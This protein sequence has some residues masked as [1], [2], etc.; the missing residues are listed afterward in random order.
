VSTL[1]RVCLSACMRLFET[2]PIVC[3]AVVAGAS[4]IFAI[5][6][7]SPFFALVV[8]GLP[9]LQP[10]IWTQPAGHPI[11]WGTFLSVL[12]WNTSGYDSVGALAAEV[13]RPGQEFPRAMV[14]TIF[15]VTLV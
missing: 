10:R 9:E 13:R 2:E 14:A 3:M 5:L 6:V 12:L 15:L 11:E 1:S 8:C 4:T 7:I